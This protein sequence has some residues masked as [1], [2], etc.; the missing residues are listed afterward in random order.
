MKKEVKILGAIALL[1]II[2]ALVGA[3]YY[4]SSVQNERVGGNSNGGGRS[5][6]VTETLVVT[7][8]DQLHAG[9]SE[10]TS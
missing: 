8:V 3:S 4:R 5:S 10:P 7:A 2:G 6:L 9:A 1:A